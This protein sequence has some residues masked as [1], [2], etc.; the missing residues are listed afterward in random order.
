MSKERDYKAEYAKYQ[1]TDEQK[2]NRAK[3]NAA[4]R[5]MMREGKVSKGDGKHV[6]H[7]TPLS[8]GGGNGKGNLT[9][10]DAGE[11]FSYSRTKTGAMKGN[12]S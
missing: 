7:V 4:R 12:R 6:N 5:Q 1:G 8:K 2:K 9:V 3:R 10:K 11:N